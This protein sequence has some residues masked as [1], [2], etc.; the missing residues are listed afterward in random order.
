M[1]R[2][3]SL[4]SRLTLGLAFCGLKKMPSLCSIIIIKMS[5]TFSQYTG[6]KMQH[7]LNYVL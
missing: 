3:H 2:Q 5:S 1:S 4:L 7:F 6:Q